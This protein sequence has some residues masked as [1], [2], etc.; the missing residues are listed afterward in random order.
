MNVIKK[1]NHQTHS[2]IVKRKAVVGLTGLLLV[3][4]VLIFIPV[5]N[6]AYWQGWAFFLAFSVPVTIISFYFLN[7]DLRL[8]ETRVKAG[9]IAEKEIKQKIIQ[10]FAGF[11]FICVILFPGIDHRFGWSN[12][13]LFL[14]IFGDILVILG[15]CIVFFVFRENT[16]ASGTIE[17]NKEQ[18]VVQTG[19]YSIVRHPMYSGAFV[20]LVGTPLALGSWWGLIFVFL[21]FIIIIWRLFDEEMFL[22]KNL[23]GYTSYCQKVRFRLIPFIW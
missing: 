19:P 16:Y 17:V 12:V 22:L 4:W 13:S 23:P 5:W 1:E 11:F 8:I 7:H 14:S 2:I 15:L 18:N 3:L 21:L 20:M 9:P 6:V 10:T